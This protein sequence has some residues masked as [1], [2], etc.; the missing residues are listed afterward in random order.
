[1][2]AY[3]AEGRALRCG[4]AVT[5]CVHVDGRWIL[6]FDDGGEAGPFDG[7]L[8]TAPAPQAAA[9]LGRAHAWFDR[10]SSVAYAPCITAMA[11]FD[12]AVDPEADVF[13]F[14]D[15]P[16]ATAVRGRTPG[17]W[18]LHG[19]TTY[20]LTELDTDPETSAGRLVEAWGHRLGASRTPSW[21]RA[22]RWRFARA[23]ADPLVLRPPVDADALLAVA[24]DAFGGGD[25]EG[26]WLSG[27]SA[28]ARLRDALFAR[29]R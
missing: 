9:L 13:E 22:H 7:L 4:S 20:S 26:A 24:G 17:T 15:G 5:A 10:L 6:R 16:I 27:E 29:S 18:V 19:T 28:A 11:T 3:L 8:L 25:A 14:S 12:D 23:V 1:M 21:F 2:T